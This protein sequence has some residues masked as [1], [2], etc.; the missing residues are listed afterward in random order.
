MNKEKKCLINY[1]FT[2]L[3]KALNRN[4]QTTG[5]HNTLRVTQSWLEL[6]RQV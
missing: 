4:V 1:S 2:E 3:K 5:S 6:Y